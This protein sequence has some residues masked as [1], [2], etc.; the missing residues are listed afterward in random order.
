[1]HSNAISALPVL[2][3]IAG[4]AQAFNSHR[5]AHDQ[6]EKRGLVWETVFQ[7]VYVTNHQAAP[8]AQTQYFANSPPVVTST[9]VVQ[10]AAA[11]P[12]PQAP[13][14]QPAAN[15][16]LNVGVNLGDLLPG[17]TK[18]AGS[19]KPQ[20]TG[21]SGSTG[22]AKRGI[23][24][25]DANLANS[26]SEQCV[27]CGWLYNWGSSAPGITGNKNFIPMLWGDLPVHTTNWDQDAEA[28]IANGAKHFF[29]FNE[30]DMPSQANMSPAAAAA[31]HA[32]YMSKYSGKVQ[33][34]APSVSNS[35]QAGQGLD[36][37]KQFMT[38]CAS[39]D[40]CEVDF[41]NVHWYSQAQYSDTL[42]SHLKDAN[43]ACGG[44]PVWLTEF[45][46]IDSDN[47]ISS[48]MNSVIPKLEALDYLAGYA[49][50]MVADNNLMTS[51]SLSSIGNVYASIKS[52]FA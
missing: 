1:M 34:G 6:A 12:T 49:Y 32:K 20:A 7:T 24:Y 13:A 45:A 52:L 4:Q 39:T 5:H 3:A 28:A 23:A 10:A 31:A 33:V 40:G 47:E 44:K 19:S 43:D 14:A 41:C 42:F 36:W 38:A 18:T 22:F 37:L 51:S 15:A 46:P 26:F 50:F 48:F 30:P 35:G 8:A 17:N 21:S 16:G 9:V 2:A 29:S 11:Q 27:G 25:N